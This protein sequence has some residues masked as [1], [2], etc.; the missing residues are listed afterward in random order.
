MFATLD[1]ITGSPRLILSGRR[2]VTP[3]GETLS[4]AALLSRAELVAR[5]VYPV[6][7]PGAPDPALYRVTGQRVEI[8]GDGATL[9]YDAEPIPAAEVRAAKVAAIKAQADAL[10]SPTDWLVIRQAEGGAVAPADTLA[11]RAAV[12]EASNTAEAAVIAAA[13][14]PAAIVAVAAEWPEIAPEETV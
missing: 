14:D 7:D 1:P 5:G 10:L 4:D 13:D 11:Y 6:T 2:L 8:D 9:V 3:A 12:R